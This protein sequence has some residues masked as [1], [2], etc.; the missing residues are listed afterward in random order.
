MGGSG[1][2]WR[3]HTA[4][5]LMAG[6]LAQVVVT[7]HRQGEKLDHFELERG[8]IVVSDGGYGYRSS[9]AA[10]KKKQAEGVFRFYPDTF[11][12]QDKCGQPLD[13]WPLLRHTKG[14]R[15]WDRQAYCLHNKQSYAVRVI[16]CKLPPEQAGLARK[17]AE[18]RAQKKGPS[19]VLK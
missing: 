17:R 5:D 14:A 9:V 7:D 16:A 3:L 19:A 18:K 4:Y 1:D 12:L 6:R 13:L 11:P 15:M 10:V 8:D 2:D